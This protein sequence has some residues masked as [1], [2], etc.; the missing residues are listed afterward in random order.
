M[1]NP[2]NARCLA[3]SLPAMVGLSLWCGAIQATPG[4]NA[5]DRPGNYPDRPVTLVVPYPPGGSTDMAARIIAAEL[6]KNLD[7][8][9]IVE[10]RSGGGGLVGV[11]SVVRSQPDGY[12]LAVGVSGVLTIWPALGREMPF[13]PLRDLAPITMIVDNPLVIA[14]NNDFPPD[15]MAELRTYAEANPGP[16]SFGSGGQGT[17]MH[18]AGA[19]LANMTDIDLS[20]VPYRGTNPALQDVLAGHIPLAIID[21]ATV[22]E[23]VAQGQVKGLATTGAERSPTMPELPTVAESGVEGFSV[24]SWFGVL[25]PKDTP[26]DIVRFLNQQITEILER[27]EI[28]E[29]FLSAGLEPSTNTPEVFRELITSETARYRD[30]IRDNHITIE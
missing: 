29:R 27:P 21:A 5:V 4:D 18:L 11:N 6:S 9:V 7:Q 13:D 2:F 3:R 20:H 25:A 1:M 26:E 30:V 8:S 19:R 14:A 17:A 24:T 22:R 16:L 10:N 28:Q 12:T 15:T 23:F